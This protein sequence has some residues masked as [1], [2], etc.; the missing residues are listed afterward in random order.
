MS[1]SAKT[2]RNIQF[3]LLGLNFVFVLII[4]LELTRDYEVAVNDGTDTQLTVSNNIIAPDTSLKP[5]DEYEQII[6]R[7]LFTQYRRPFAATVVETLQRP[8]RG[9]ANTRKTQDQYLLSAI[10]I[11]DDKRIALL[12]SKKKQQVT[13]I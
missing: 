3:A 11:T 6:E 9:K 5:L 10:V 2:S 4:I 12:Q 1:T 7:P 13:E 8:R